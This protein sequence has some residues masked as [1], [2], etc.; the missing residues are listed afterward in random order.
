VEGK[1]RKAT[2]A[3]DPCS[4]LATTELGENVDRAVG[5]RCRRSEG[6]ERGL[7]GHLPG[8]G[9]VGPDTYQGDLRLV[10]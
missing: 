3:L 10:K 8:S 9:S 5:E 2:D 1:S 7:H 6:E 4:D